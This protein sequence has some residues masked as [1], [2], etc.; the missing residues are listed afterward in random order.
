MDLASAR[1]S[2]RRVLRAVVSGFLISGRLRGAVRGRNGT[3]RCAAPGR[4]ESVQMCVL[5]CGISHPES[6]RGH[7][8]RFQL[9]PL[10]VRGSARGA[11]SLAR[12][13]EGEDGDRRRARSTAALF[14]GLAGISD[15]DV[16][17]GRT[18]GWGHHILFVVHVARPDWPGGGSGRD[19]ARTPPPGVPCSSHVSRAKLNE[20]PGE[21]ARFWRPVRLLLRV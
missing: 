10:E 9:G 17:S 2:H 11:V 15:I 3:S 20:V 7:L 14:F 12:F 16:G 21:G 18:Y 19:R 5:R 4:W 8:R 13:P 1:L 6:G